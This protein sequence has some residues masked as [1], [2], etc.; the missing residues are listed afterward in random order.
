[1]NSSSITSSILV[2]HLWGYCCSNVD[3]ASRSSCSNI[4]LVIVDYNL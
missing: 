3:G 2:F 1:M 4:I